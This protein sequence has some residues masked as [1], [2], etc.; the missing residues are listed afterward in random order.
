MNLLERDTV[1]MMRFA[2]LLRRMA[3]ASANALDRL[4]GYDVFVAHRRNDGAEYA[5]RLV[6]RFDKER[7]YA[8]ID[9]REYGAGDDL[10]I[11]TI[12]HIRKATML[13]VIGS[14]AILQNRDPDWVLKEIET[15]IAEHQGDNRRILP[16]DFGG[17]LLEVNNYSPIV[18][19]LQSTIRVTEP[20]EALAAQPSDNVVHA[21]TQQFRKR[22]RDIVRLRIFQTIGVVLAALAVS[23]GTLAW[24]A[25]KAL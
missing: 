17:T 12:R 24:F 18:T 25:N 15:Y 20:L 1:K 16:I 4:F 22:R 5:A 13:V 8:F 10:S 6:E 19:L 11:S 9:T 21:V 7:L 2:E 3:R 23:S 14:P